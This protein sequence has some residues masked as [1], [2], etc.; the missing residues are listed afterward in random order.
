MENEPGWSRNI[1]KGIVSM[2][3]LDM[4]NIRIQTPIKSHSFITHE[5]GN[6]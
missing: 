1:K 6:D 4:T 5:V 3:Q 2:L